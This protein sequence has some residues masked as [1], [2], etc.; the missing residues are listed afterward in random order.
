[1]GNTMPWI[2]AVAALV[3]SS[4]RAQDIAGDWQGTLKTGAAERRIVLSI[5]KQADGGWTAAM[6]VVDSGRDAIP[7]SSVTLQGSNLT[8]TIDALGDRYEGK[9]SADGATIEGTWTPQ[10]QPIPLALKRA[11]KET[12]WRSDPSPHSLQ[13]ITVDKDVRLEV[14]DW[15]GSGRPVVLLTG[16]GNNSGSGW[17]MLDL[18]ELS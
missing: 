5:A 2:M 10:G 13:F 14:L 16:L 11:T 8:L 4:I 12:S 18:P 9:V 15:G 6:L 1:M 3:A 17:I 7:A